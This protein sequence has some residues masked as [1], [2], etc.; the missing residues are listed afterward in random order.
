MNQYKKLF[1]PI[2]IRNMTLDN[3]LVMAPMGTNFGEQNGEMNFLHMNYYERRAKGGDGLLIVE[4]ACVKYPE[5]SN[6]T[7]QLRIDAD[8]YIP[9]LYKLCETIHQYGTKIAIQLNHAGASAME[10]LIGIQPV[11]ASATPN[12]AGGA[13]PHALTV[14]ENYSIA[15]D[16]A[17]AAKRAQTIGFDAIEIHAGYSYL[18]SQFLSPLTFVFVITNSFSFEK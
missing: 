17:A 13:I 7:T 2:T 1:E 9:R 16:Y 10:S 18:I 3:R 15:D 5:G 8:N 11:S 4:N 14:E 6:G 12:K